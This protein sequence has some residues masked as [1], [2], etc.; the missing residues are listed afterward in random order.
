MRLHLPPSLSRVLSLLVLPC[1]ASGSGSQGTCIRVN[2]VFNLS[3]A[4]ELA[5]YNM[6][7]SDRPCFSG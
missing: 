6:V 1:L 7:L 3:P 2:F 4:L 5:L